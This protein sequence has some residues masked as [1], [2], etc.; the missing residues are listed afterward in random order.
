MRYREKDLVHESFDV[1]G[2]V[3]YFEAHV[4]QYPFRDIDQYL[5]KMDRY[6]SLRS[7]VLQNGGR[8]FR[9]HQLVGRP[10]YTFIKMYGLRL[11]ILDGMPGLI[12]SGL[13]TYYTFI[14]YAK[15]WELEK[16][17]EDRLNRKPNHF[18]YPGN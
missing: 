5:Q 2:K 3:G 18:E 11:G 6:S 17:L 4:E 16:G 1:D 8:K 13:Y 9:F 7:Q 14:K 15:L 10:L 12:L